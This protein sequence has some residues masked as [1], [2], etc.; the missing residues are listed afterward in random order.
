MHITIYRGPASQ[1]CYVFSC[2]FYMFYLCVA[3]PKSHVHDQSMEAELQTRFGLPDGL[4]DGYSLRRGDT[5]RSL[6]CCIKDPG[7]ASE[8]DPRT[9]A[10]H[11]TNTVTQWAYELTFKGAHSA[12]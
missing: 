4:P 7:K 2:I 10:E 12:S 6:L 3:I 11:G 5:L 1:V 8:M 9:R